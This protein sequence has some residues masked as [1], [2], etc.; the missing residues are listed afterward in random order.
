MKRHASPAARLAL[1]TALGGGITTFFVLDLHQWLSFAALKAGQLRL[2]ELRAAAPLAVGGG[3][4]ALYVAVTALSLPGATI[5]GLAAGALFGLATG[6]VLVSFASSIGA[7]LAFLSARFLL[8]DVLERRFGE[9]LRAIDEGIARDGAFYLFTLRLVP[10]FPFFLV[11]LLL[12]LTRL[13]TGTFY[14]VSQAGMLPGTLVYVNAGTQLGR[15]EDPAGI[16]S[17]ALLASFALLGMFP[18]VARAAV[19]RLRAR[20]VYARW[21]RPRRFDRNL[22]VIGAGAAG[23]VAS[24]VGAT[25]KAKVT[26]VESG[27]MGGDCL[28]HGCV[29]CKALL[30]SAR[31]AQQIRNAHRYGLPDGEP[32]VDFRALMQRIRHIIET[33]APHD[34]VERYRGLGVDV[35]QGRA[36]LLDPWTVEIAG[37]DGVTRRL[38]TRGIVI[39]TGARPVVPAIPGLEECGYLTSDTV[40][41][42]FATLDAP[43]PRLVVLGAGPLGCELAQGFAR[44]GSQV[45]VVETGTRIL[46]REDEDVAACA[47]AALAADG[48]ELL[49]AHQALRCEREGERRCLVVSSAEAERRIVFDA[50][51]CAVGRSARL[52][53][54]GL[55]ELGI[56]TGRTIATNDYLQTL[57]PNIYAAGDVAGPHQFTHT[58][59]HQAWHAAVNAL[60]GDLKRVRADLSVIPRTTFTDPEIAQ[61]GLNEQE[62]QARGIAYELTHYNLEELDRAITDGAAHGFVKVLT[63]PR[64]DRILGVT[65]VGEH[66][67]EML[68]EFVLAMR[69][70]L[71]LNRI[72][73]SVHAYPTLTEA[74]RHAAG[75]WK[76]AHAPAALL[77]WSE[78]Y[79]A[80]R[81]R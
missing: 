2:V 9:R 76:R 15:I 4:F 75:Q 46:G 36:R 14:R 44:L 78:R 67:G 73:G 35:V 80:W 10:L 6:T 34:S 71:G 48:V 18:F 19:Q 50:L 69:N 25:L 8:R 7:T 51:L 45:V 60:F 40:W 17:P 52:E 30:R 64:S 28:N 27:R 77:A 39:A 56:Q 70:G 63:R 58:A 3:F 55:D 81:R 37:H 1:L 62:A 57:Y 65:I 42:A 20:R 59:A 61:V 12:G 74:N 13:G 72:L 41:D 22:V 49:T 66:A 53:G 21:P 33:I 68:A 24:Y 32:A 11:N 23:L 54:Y 26:L 43:P 31:L 79:H 38:T 16:L 47:H 29:P 5:L